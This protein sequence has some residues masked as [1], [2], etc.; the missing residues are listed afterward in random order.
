MTLHGGQRLG[1]AG[2]SSRG[3]PG[4]AEQ[5]R[6]L[7]LRSAAEI[8]LEQGLP[9]GL[10]V[11]L[12]DACRRIGRTNGSAYQI[13]AT[14]EDFR[15]EVAVYIARHVDYA[16]TSTLT[17]ASASEMA[18]EQSDADLVRAVARRYLEQLVRDPF[19]YVSL[20][21]WTAHPD[22]EPEIRDAVRAGYAEI[23]TQFEQF[24]A[25]FFELFGRQLIDGW[26]V[27]RLTTAVTALT[28]G[29]ALR[30]RFAVDDAERTSV[31]EVYADLLAHLLE[32][33]APVGS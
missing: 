8:I 28:E 13:W 4:A 16:G 23:Q 33:L 2:R 5:T 6:Q 7:L 15:R 11:K 32:T 29:C 20:T 21:F 14:Q 12:S 10:P 9:G 24:F 26:T 19:F 17:E 1:D 3:R 22:S 18:V 25:G 31:I 30:H 27:G